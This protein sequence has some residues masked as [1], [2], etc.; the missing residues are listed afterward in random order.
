M[1]LL[2]DQESPAAVRSQVFTI[3]AG[4]RSAAAAVGAALA[5]AASGFGASWLVAGIAAVWIGSGLLLRL[6]PAR[7]RG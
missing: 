3:G 2:R 4:L 1:L 6:F 5:G 7:E